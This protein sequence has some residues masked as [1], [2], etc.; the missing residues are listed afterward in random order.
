MT[1]VFVVSVLFR[2]ILASNI[3][4]YA[5][6]YDELVHSRIAHS[7]ASGTGISFRGTLYDYT[8]ILY[9]LVISPAFLLV[10]N[11]EGAHQII[12]WMNAIM[13][14]SAIYPIYM[15]A[16][17]Y[18]KKPLYIWMAT[19]YGI[20]IGEM[21]YTYSVIQENLNYPL[22]MCFFF[23]FSEIVIDRECSAKGLCVLAA[24]T[25][26]LTTCK[27]MNLVIPFAVVLFF[28]IQAITCREKRGQIFKNVCL[29]SV[30]FLTLKLAYSLV[31]KIFL[32]NAVEPNGILRSLRIL[33]DPAIMKQL[34]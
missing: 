32:G 14:S 16:Q 18:L 7:I 26:L 6:F 22:M 34:I 12:L 4:E 28:L 1:L 31:M 33:F 15:L 25:F 5:V 2:G 19:I 13:M 3:G 29:F 30:V 17:K 27:Q 24:F 21:A 23:L 8:E 10:K 11:T 9:S 20:L